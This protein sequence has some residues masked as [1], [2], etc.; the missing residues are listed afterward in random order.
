M[1]LKQS[2]QTNLNSNG[3]VGVIPKPGGGGCFNL[4]HP[5]CGPHTNTIF[6]VK[7][8]TRV[9]QTFAAIDHSLSAKTGIGMSLGINIF[10]ESGVGFE[11]MMNLL[12]RLLLFTFV[13]VLFGIFMC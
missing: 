9:D 4:S 1:V 11:H 6:G 2:D 5:T 13:V 7:A 8:L 3:C 12:P 10:M